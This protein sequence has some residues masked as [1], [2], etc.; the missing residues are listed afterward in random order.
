M[1]LFS[2]ISTVL[3]TWKKNEAEYSGDFIALLTSLTLHLSILH[4]F[5]ATNLF[6]SVLSGSRDAFANL[7]TK[8]V[9]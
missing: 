9:L 1:Q 6:F 5:S 8:F 4:Y 2:N 7:F 3:N